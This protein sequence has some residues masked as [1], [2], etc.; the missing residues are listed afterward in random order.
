[1]WSFEVC[2]RRELAPETRKPFGR[3]PAA[4]HLDH[5][6]IVTAA[7]GVERVSRQP[8]N[9]WPALSGRRSWVSLRLASSAC[10][11]GLAWASADSFAAFELG[12]HSLRNIFWPCSART[13]RRC[14]W[15]HAR[16]CRAACSAR[17]PSSSLSRSIS[18]SA[19]ASACRSW[20]AASTAC[21]HRHRPSVS[22]RSGS[23]GKRLRAR[24][25]RNVVCG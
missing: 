4:R 25:S 16:Q 15:R 9:P 10:L 2:G 17:R 18:S 19:A 7:Q 21:R 13:C 8:P 23:T 22:G 24:P 5:E 11:P 3:L 14:W 1:M 12:E 6:R 20:R